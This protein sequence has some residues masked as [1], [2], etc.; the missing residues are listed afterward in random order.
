MTRDQA[1]GGTIGNDDEFEAA[2]AG[3]I[4]AAIDS[5]VDVRGAWE[6]RSSDTMHEWEVQVVELDRGSDPT[7][8]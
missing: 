1:D 7:K 5:G 6:V 8:R 2:L 3:V 4:E